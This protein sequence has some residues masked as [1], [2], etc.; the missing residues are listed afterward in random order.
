ME[1]QVDNQKVQ[2]DTQ[3]HIGTLEKLLQQIDQ[4]NVNDESKTKL[5]DALTAALEALKEKDEKPDQEP[6]KN[7][8]GLDLSADP[9]AD[10]LLRV[11]QGRPSR[12]QQRHDE[13]VNTL[14]ELTQGTSHVEDHD[15]AAMFLARLVKD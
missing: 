6:K 13:A 4:L 10:H 1:Q 8:G 11:A 5:A 12:E 15:E 2:N 7:T 3:D 9:I 14:V